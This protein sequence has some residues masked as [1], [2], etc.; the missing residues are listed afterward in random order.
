MFLHSGNEIKL[1]R[2]TFLLLAQ[3]NNLSSQAQVCKSVHLLFGKT[4]PGSPAQK[5]VGSLGFTIP[6]LRAH[7]SRGP[8]AWL[9][10]HLTADLGGLYGPLPVPLRHASLPAA[11]MP[12]T[13][14]LCSA[15]SFRHD[16]SA[17]EPAGRGLKPQ[18]NSTS[19]PLSCGCQ[20]LHL[21]DKKA[22]TQEV[23]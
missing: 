11:Q 7:G 1:V 23:H 3:D 12:R 4:V 6:A 9:L 8:R 15:T 10:P 13:K 17:L 2:F 16:V 20:V 22:N 14:Q 19:H 18:A 21:S 5:G